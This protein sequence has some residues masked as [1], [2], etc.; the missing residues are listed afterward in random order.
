MNL[1]ESSF[2]K[3]KK[4]SVAGKDVEKSVI[5]KEVF[6][7]ARKRLIE[8]LGYKDVD[9]LVVENYLAL[10]GNAEKDKKNKEYEDKLKKL[11]EESAQQE[12]DKNR[13][14]AA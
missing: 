10:I 11:R 6:E 12:K 2:P 1:I 7:S 14:L 8:Q 4:E 3:V 13:E 9:D 5:S